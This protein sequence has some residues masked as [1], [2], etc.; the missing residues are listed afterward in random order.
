LCSR[1]GIT[2][3]TVT[4]RLSLLRFHKNVL[5]IQ[6]GSADGAER[7][8]SL[9]PTATAQGT[10][11]PSPMVRASKQEAAAAAAPSAED[12]EVALGS[13]SIVALYYHSSTSYQIH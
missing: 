7:S 9:R 11:L 12:V 13:G 10:D 4:H 6:G 1:S 3:L 2:L 5:K 8:W